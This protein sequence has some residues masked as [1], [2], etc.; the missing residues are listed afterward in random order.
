MNTLTRRKFLGGATA[1]MALAARA[2][3]EEKGSADSGLAI[4]HTTDLHGHILSTESYEGEKDLGGLARCASQIRAWRKQSPHHLLLDIGDVYQ[5]TLVSWQTRG[6]LMIDLFNKLGY[7]AWVLG[8]HEFDWGPEVV[9]EAL[10]RSNMPVLAANVKLDGKLVGAERTEGLFQKLRP[11]IMREVAG[12]KVAVIGLITPGLPAWLRPELLGPL[13]AVD[14]APVLQRC[15]AEVKSE[16]ATKI[17][18]AG[19]MGYRERGDDYANPLAHTL[20]DSGVQAY[21]GG[22]SHRRN[23]R[24]LV[25]GVP[26]TQASYHGLDC[27]RVRFMAD[28]ARMELARMDAAVA[29]DEVVLQAARPFLEKAEAETARVVGQVPVALSGTAAIRDFL[30]EA[31]LAAASRSGEEAEG[32]FHGTFGTKEI[33]RGDFTVADAWQHLPYENRLVLAELTSEELVAV[34]QEAEGDR[35]SDRALFGLQVI[36]DAAGKVVAV[37]GT[38]QRERYRVIFNSYD[39]QSGGRRLTTLRDIL[40]RPAA[41]SRLI[42]LDTREALLDYV[43]D[44]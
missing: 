7:D 28:L 12:E 3:A 37:R 4:F 38:P 5:G 32:V 2:R 35:Y 29:S 8:N 16:G 36:R 19:H 42:P 44:L 39:A 22:H 33:A 14:P 43:A 34:L 18:V 15:V 24:F 6:K 21:L 26:C 31:F 11:W 20:R 40:A 25:E 27:G 17:I 41:R 9:E 1:A 10:N 13:E 30:A 23:E